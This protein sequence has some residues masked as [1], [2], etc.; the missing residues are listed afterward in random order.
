MGERQVKPVHATRPSDRGRAAREGDG[1]P[2]APRP[3]DLD[4]AP[5]HAHGQPCTERLQRRLFGGEAGREVLG[6]V[7]PGQG[8]GLLLGGEHPI[9]EALPPAVQEPPHSGD[10]AEVD[11]GADDH[12]PDRAL[13]G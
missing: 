8:V 6:R 2:L 4:L 1:R 5:A 11:P 3:K 12:E 9:E 7:V 13:T 10:L